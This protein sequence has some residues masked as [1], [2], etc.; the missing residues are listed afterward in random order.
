MKQGRTGLT[1]REI[2]AYH[3]PSVELS[4]RKVGQWVKE[5][6][7]ANLG[8]SSRNVYHILVELNQSIVEPDKRLSILQKILPVAQELTQALEKQFLK[9]IARLP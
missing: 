9:Y 4:P 3:Q 1:L 8:D 6:P 5:L 7:I 2:Q